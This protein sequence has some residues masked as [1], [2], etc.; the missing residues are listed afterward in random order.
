[1]RQ[2]VY[3]A[4]SLLFGPMPVGCYFW[5]AAAHLLK[6]IMTPDVLSAKYQKGNQEE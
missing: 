3:R 1:M 5:Q 4:S 2:A 6:P